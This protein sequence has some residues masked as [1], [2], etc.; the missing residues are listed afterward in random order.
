M[1]GRQAERHFLE[2]SLADLD[3]EH[4]AGDLTDDDHARLRATYERRLAALDRP[5]R[6]APAAAPPRGRGTALTVAVVALVAVV[7][8]VALA[9]AVGRRGAGDNVSGI[10]LSPEDDDG[11]AAT[12]TTLPPALAAC[13]ELRGSEALDCYL[14]YTQA[15]PT[16]PDGFVY[17]GLFSV[18]QGL[19]SGN[20]DLLEA[21]TTFLRRALE[22]DPGDL[23][24]RANLAVVLER[25]GQ[26]DAAREVLAPL[27]GRD[28]LPED[29]QQLVDFVAGNL[30][31][32]GTGTTAAP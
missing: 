18:N 26:A 11:S 31:P 1:T 29:I 4:A 17:F 3:E 7:A 25:T 16:D 5:R 23:Q 14:D 28:D 8:G 20:D 2:R 32:A 22:L 10:D 21:G 24:A 13:F 30:D 19:E 27:L 6:S 9:G 12:V 15:N